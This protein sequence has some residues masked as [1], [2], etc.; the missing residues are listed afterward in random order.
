M[1]DGQKIKC[2][3]SD[4]QKVLKLGEIYTV[5]TTMLTADNRVYIKE[6]KRFSFSK[7]RFEI[8]G[9]HIGDV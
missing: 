3:N 1:Y 2:I 8:V 4:N 6:W 9:E 7:D 5:D